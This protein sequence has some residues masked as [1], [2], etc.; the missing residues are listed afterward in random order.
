MLGRMNNPLPVIISSVPWAWKKL[1]QHKER[2]MHKSSAQRAVAGNSSLTSIPAC[3]W[4][5][6]V[7]GDGNA[8]PSGRG[9]PKST[10]V[11][12]SSTGSRRP[13]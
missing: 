11:F 7:Q 9:R 5:A 1:S 10:L 8:L 13:S 4:R 6:N 3:P 12:S 2:T